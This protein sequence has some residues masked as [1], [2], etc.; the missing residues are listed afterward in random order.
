MYR[1]KAKS[2]ELGVMLAEYSDA[3][4]EVIDILRGADWNRNTLETF[5]DERFEKVHFDSFTQDG[6]YYTTYFYQLPHGITLNEEEFMVGP[7]SVRIDNYDVYAFECTFLSNEDEIKAML[8][9]RC[10]VTV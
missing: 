2:E 10:I 5:M 8:P 1:F 6:Q 3:V 7:T 9:E 4:H